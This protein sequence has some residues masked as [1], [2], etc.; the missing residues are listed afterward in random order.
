MLL[1]PPSMRMGTAPEVG[2]RQLD[3]AG[4][5]LDLEGIEPE[6]AKIS[7]EPGYTAPNRN[8]PGYLRV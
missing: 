3:P 6:S 2:K 4:A 5:T 7:V 8:P 1:A